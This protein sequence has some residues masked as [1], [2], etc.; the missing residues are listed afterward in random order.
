MLLNGIDEGS[1]I[2]CCMEMCCY[3]NADAHKTRA[4]PRI[5]LTTTECFYNYIN[6][7]SF[8]ALSTVLI[9]KVFFTWIIN[10]QKKWWIRVIA[11]TYFIFLSIFYST[12]SDAGSLNYTSNNW[13][14]FSF[15]CLGVEHV[16]LDRKSFKELSNGKIQP[17]YSFTNFTDK[18]VA[19]IMFPRNYLVGSL[20]CIDVMKCDVKK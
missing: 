8:E 1:H 19:E 15:G 18:I 5:A 6:S 7:I 17:K 13:F 4:Q 12:N 16:N 2:T 14:F 20:R 9:R 11:F 3:F 10:N